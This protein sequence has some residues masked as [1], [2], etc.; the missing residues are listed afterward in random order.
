M[1]FDHNG[2]TVAA[3]VSSLDTS[4]PSDVHTGV[5]KLLDAEKLVKETRYGALCTDREVLFFT[6]GMTSM[7]RLS[8]SAEHFFRW[9]TNCLPD[10]ECS[11]DMF[12]Q[13]W[14]RR[15]IVRTLKC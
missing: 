9:F 1:T 11:R 7:G 14:S 6:F 13:Y 5:G 2:V 3:D 10:T 8:S 4:A 15:V 12:R